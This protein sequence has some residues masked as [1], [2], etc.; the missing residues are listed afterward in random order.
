MLGRRDLGQVVVTYVC[1]SGI[2]QSRK[3]RYFTE[4][5]GHLE[6][7]Q[8]VFVQ[9]VMVALLLRTCQISHR[10]VKQLNLELPVATGGEACSFHSSS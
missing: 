9:S 7:V 4:V 6:S 5:I 2:S 1:I 3:N 8:S 10:N